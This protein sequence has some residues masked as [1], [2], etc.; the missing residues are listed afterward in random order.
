M[1]QTKALYNNHL[2][3]SKGQR[4]KDERQEF[5][6]VNTSRPVPHSCDFRL[7]VGKYEMKTNTG[8]GKN[9]IINH[10]PSAKSD[11]RNS[12]GTT[13]MPKETIRKLFTPKSEK[14]AR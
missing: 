3:C 11:E 14:G 7:S 1:I 9:S 12:H 10:E 4:A 2:V 13:I 6:Y 8:H 5:K